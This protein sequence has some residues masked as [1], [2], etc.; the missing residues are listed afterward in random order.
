[1]LLGVSV[2]Y[3]DFIFASLVSGVRVGS[4]ERIGLF[5]FMRDFLSFSLA[6]SL[7]SLVSVSKDAKWCYLPVNFGLCGNR[8]TWLF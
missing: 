2:I 3:S 1:M 5:Y 4:H 6:L 8:S 7:G